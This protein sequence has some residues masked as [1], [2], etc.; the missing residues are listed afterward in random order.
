MTGQEAKKIILAVDDMPLNL[1]AIRTILHNDFDIRLAKSAGM[2]LVMLNAIK[3]DLILADIEMP[4]MS[5]FEL[6]E[7]L[8]NNSEH[9]EQKDIP[10]IFVTSHEM[11]D[12]VEQALSSGA[13]Y[14]V[15]PV[16][17]RVLLEK[18]NSV[19]EA[20]EKNSTSG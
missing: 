19:F 2:A 12:I 7:R 14:V 17:P 11:P 15:K 3:V 10:V 16:I 9:P 4:E 1:T 18:V 20:A 5:G 13:G 6:V 8:R